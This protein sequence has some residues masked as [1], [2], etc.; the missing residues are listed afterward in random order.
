MKNFSH[1]IAPGDGLSRRTVLGGM[2]GSA[3]LCALPLAAS[4]K[5]SNV[6]EFSLKA[7]PGTA[8]ILG[9][10]WADTKVWNYSGQTPGPVLRVTQGD[11]VRIHVENGLDQPTT[12]HWHGLRI[13]INMDG[14]PDISQAPI[15][16]GETFTYEFVVP[17]AGTFWYHPH[18]NTSEQIARGL[19]GILIVEEK[20]PPTVDRE[21]LWVIDDWRLNQ[22]ATI[23]ENFGH[24]MDISHGGRQGNL[25][26]INGKVPDIFSVRSG[27]RIRLRLA[28]VANARLFGLRFEGHEP[29]VIAIDGHPVL[30]HVPQNGQLILAPGQRVDIILDCTAK[31]GT[32]FKVMD[33]IYADQAYALIDIAYSKDK[34][35]RTKLLGKIKP[36]ADNPL[37]EPNLA[38]PNR[39]KYEVIIDGGAMGSMQ[40]ADFKGQYL[41]INELIK[42]RR[43]WAINGVAADTTAMA[44]MYTVKRGSTNVFSI[45]NDTV[46]PHPMHL[47]GHAFR[48]LSIN[49][50]AELYRPWAD[51]VL[52]P[53]Q[54]SAKIAFVADNPGDWLFHCHILE[55]VDGG[56]LSV[57]RVR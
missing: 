15:Q 20:S 52:L 25:V 13:P 24:G 22:D 34:P 47:H 51:T 57:I 36:L 44:P 1:D 21:E 35:V 41:T 38:D 45:K 40:G 11:R 46:F 8:T 23:Q 14:V 39:N 54:G 48:I 55:H 37:S 43:I 27:E 50:Q 29:Q 5:A 30:P 56:M 2:A 12:I 9:G 7:Q 53:P 31:P 16:P 10:K 49:G 26:T 32:A 19:N 3:F 42:H 17:D 28:N 18:V 6:R 4:A 33:E